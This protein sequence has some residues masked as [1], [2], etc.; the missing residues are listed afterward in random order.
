MS[1][2]Q[3]KTVNSTYRMHVVQRAYL[4]RFSSSPGMIWRYDDH[5]KH[6]G[7]ISIKKKAAVV[8]NFYPDQVEDWLASKIEGPAVEVLKLLVHAEEPLLLDEAQRIRMATYLAVQHNRTPAALEK[9]WGP[10]VSMALKKHKDELGKGGVVDLLARLRDEA[11]ADPEK[12]GFALPLAFDGAALKDAVVKMAT[13]I[14]ES[15]WT[16]S[17]APDDVLFLTTDDPMI[18]GRQP[19]KWTLFPLSSRRAL[20][21][22]STDDLELALS[23]PL[24]AERIPRSAAKNYNSQMVVEARRYLFASRKEPWVEGVRA[25]GR[26]SWWG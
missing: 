9:W 2:P 4:D 10:A 22:L 3:E 1:Q 26:T 14:Y 19:V 5:Y 7:E 17:V 12:A 8:E 24:I 13:S 6:W 16:I 18:A 21:C 23:R 11:E 25:K 15:M 20:V